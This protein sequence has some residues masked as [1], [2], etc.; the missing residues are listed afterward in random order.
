MKHVFITLFRTQYRL[1]IALTFR[2][3][4]YAKLCNRDIFFLQDT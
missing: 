3:T 2:I 1:M 4:K